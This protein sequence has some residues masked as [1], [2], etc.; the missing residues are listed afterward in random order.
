MDLNSVLPVGAAVPVVVPVV[1]DDVLNT[2]GK[3][4]AELREACDA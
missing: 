2:D 1:V 4:D 3:A